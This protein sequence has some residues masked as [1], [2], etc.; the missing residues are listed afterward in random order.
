M[1]PRA[2]PPA[3]PVAPSI[4]PMD[5]NGSSSATLFSCA[6][7][8][9]TAN[10]TAAPDDATRRNKTNYRGGRCVDAWAWWRGPVVGP[11]Y[12]DRLTVGGAFP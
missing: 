1:C 8:L 10:R 9:S 11:E 6:P 7:V 4:Q 12:N 3:S 2:P 5:R